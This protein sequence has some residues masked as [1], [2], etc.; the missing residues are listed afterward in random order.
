[1]TGPE[2]KKLRALL[3]QGGG[4]GRNDAITQKELGDVVRVTSQTIHRWEKPE[5]V[6]S[7]KT[8]DQIA[9]G[10][11]RDFPHLV[12]HIVRK[13]PDLGKLLKSRRGTKR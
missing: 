2:L 11:E 8:L 1:M 13:F 9:D 4:D 6:L 5:H 12:D 10:I 3:G 7:K